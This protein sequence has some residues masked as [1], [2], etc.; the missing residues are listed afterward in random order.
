MSKKKS[1]LPNQV[2]RRTYTTL[3]I[4]IIIYALLIYRLSYIQIVQDET[5]TQ[6]SQSQS[7]EKVALNSGRGIIYDKN[8]K[9][10][11]D[12]NK[13]NILIIPKEKLMKDYKLRELVKKTANIDDKELYKNIEQQTSSSIVEIEVFNVNSNLKKELN[14]NDI[15]VETKTLRYSS[16]GLLA[17]TIGYMYNSDNSGASGIEKSLDYLLKDSNEKYVSAFKAGQS[18][19]QGDEKIGILK[20]SI[21]TVTQDK[22]DKNVKLTIDKDIQ[23]IV[24]NIVSKEENPSVVVI[25]SVETGEIL[26]ITSRPTFDQNNVAKYNSSKKGELYNRALQVTYPPGSVF[27]IVVLYAALESGIIDENYT[28]NCTGQTKVGINNEV[29]KCHKLDGHGVETLQQA[30]SNSCNTAFYDIAK[31]VGQDKIIS[32][33]KKLH[34]EEK[35]NI[36]I[37]EEKNKIIPRD[38]KLR[39]LAIGQGSM[40]FTPLQINQLTQIIANNGTYKPLYLYDSILDSNKNIMKIFKKIKSEEIISP[41]TSTLIKEMMKDVSKE[42]TAKDLKELNGG[43][44]VKT[45]TAQSTSNGKKVNH[46]WITGFYPENQPKYNITVLVEGTEENSKSAIPIFKEI[47][48]KINKK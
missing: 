17:N 26:A 30:F 21:K 42:G 28:Y 34:L 32:A 8:G 48:E 45:G 7:L 27:K 1:I 43:S 29:L 2:V 31:K 20:G 38:I 15:L 10:L 6:K 12:I 9:N 41:Y 25:S 23:K 44:G 13:K 22:N 46:G 11:T 36:G 3:S 19:N 39:N 47:C 35:V 40:E 33:A 5:L 14:D 18:G 24:E 4:A 16:D 37:D